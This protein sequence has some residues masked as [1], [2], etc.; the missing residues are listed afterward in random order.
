MKL[1]DVCRMLF[2]LSL[3]QI[4]TIWK[5]LVNLKFS[6][7]LQ[8][9]PIHT[10]I[11]SSA[12]DQQPFYIKSFPNC[13]FANT[14]TNKYTNIEYTHKYTS[15]RYQKYTKKLLSIV[16][17]SDTFRDRKMVHGL[18]LF[19]NKVLRHFKFL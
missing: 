9:S 7:K 6:N 1:Y 2:P 4:L 15:A 10:H 8:C 19:L 3:W 11:T 16:L 18:H 14:Q 13:K 5:V 17:H 12:S